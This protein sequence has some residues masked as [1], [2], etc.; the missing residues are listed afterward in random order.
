[1]RATNCSVSP[2][3]AASGRNVGSGCATERAGKA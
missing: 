3:G 2:R 1:M